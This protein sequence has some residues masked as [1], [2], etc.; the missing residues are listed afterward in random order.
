M[1]TPDVIV[2]DLHE[3]TWQLLL[4]EHQQ[5]QHP[6]AVTLDGMKRKMIEIKKAYDEMWQ[7]IARME[8]SAA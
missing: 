8:E 1:R 6:H 5:A 3:Q 7:A 4:Q 2:N